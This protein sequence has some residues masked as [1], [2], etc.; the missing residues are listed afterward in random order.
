VSVEGHRARGCV[1]H[2]QG[3]SSRPVG[4]MMVVRDITDQ[5][6]LEDEL[7]DA[8][9]RYRALVEGLTEGVVILRDGRIAY[10]NPAAERLCGCARVQL[11]ERAW[12]DLVSTADVLVTESAIGAV[13]AGASASEELRCTLLGTGGDPRAEVRVTCLTRFPH[14]RSF[15]QRVRRL[16][17][18]VRLRP[19][20]GRGTSI[21]S[22][23]R[24]RSPGG[25][26]WRPPRSWG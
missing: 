12:R 25:W 17:G 21:E 4:F 7:R 3:A 10:A 9:L 26:G 13:A 11:E 23:S 2:R 16:A 8:E 14:P 20:Q 15:C 18:T 22:V 24:R 6:R 19:T 1:G 5:M